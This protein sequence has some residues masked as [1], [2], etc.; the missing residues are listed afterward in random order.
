MPVEID[1]AVLNQKMSLVYSVDVANAICHVIEN[2]LYENKNLINQ[3]YNVC[4]DDS[5]TYIE[6][7]NLMVKLIFND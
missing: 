4:C 3:S 6:L 5:I 2:R 7:I 1:D